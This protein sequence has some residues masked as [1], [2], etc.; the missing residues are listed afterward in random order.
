MSAVVLCS[1]GLDST[2][3]LALE[4]GPDVTA[5]SIEY[6][7]RHVR[8]LNAAAHVAAFYGVTHVIIPAKGLLTGSALL[9]AAP[10]PDGRYDDESMRIT[11]VPGRNLLFAALAVAYAAGLGADRVVMGMHAGDH[12]IYPDCRPDFIGPLAQAVESAYGVELTA[13]FLMVD[14][15]EIVRRGAAVGVPYELTWSCYKGGGLHCGRCGTCVERIEA[16]RLAGVPDPT[17]YADPEFAET[18]L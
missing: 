2:T 6:G 12:P 14:K 9:G 15:A 11:V 7:Q 3:A 13:P 1:G 16:F 5:I 4:R 17:T 10:V 18:V 8:E